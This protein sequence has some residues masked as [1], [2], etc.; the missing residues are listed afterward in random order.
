MIKVFL[1]Y[2]PLKAKGVSLLSLGRFILCFIHIGACYCCSYDTLLA[3]ALQSREKGQGKRVVQESSNSNSMDVAPSSRSNELQNSKVSLSNTE[4]LSPENHNLVEVCRVIPNILLDIRYAT[5]H[6]FLGFSLYAKPAC[7]LHKKVADA[8]LKVQEELASMGLGLKIFDGY[9]P[10]SVQQLMWKAVKDERYVAN[11]MQGGRHTRGTAVDLTLVNHE[12]R[13]LEMPT[14]YDD[15]TEKAHSDYSDL[16][17]KT[18]QNRALL[19]NVMK[20]QGFQQLPTEWW[21][22]D[23]EGWNDDIQFPSLDI[24]LEQLK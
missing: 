21:H 1:K 17:K 14:S 13:E 8:L 5:A 16:P 22:F 24:E 15:F 23:F 9:R 20:R 12:G 19:A 4:K 6:N 3:F 18:L 2:S 7:Y 10:L 11:P